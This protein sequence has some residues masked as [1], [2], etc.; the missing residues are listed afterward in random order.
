MMIGGRESERDHMVDVFCAALWLE[1]LGVGWL[2]GV[3][4][5]SN[6]ETGGEKKQTTV[7]CSNVPRLGWV[8][9]GCRDGCFLFPAVV[10]CGFSL[11]LFPSDILQNVHA[12]ENF[13]DLLNG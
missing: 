8:A 13:V 12:F 7:P 3:A 9:F 10:V 1:W 6:Q 4:A 5:L 2:V 11:L